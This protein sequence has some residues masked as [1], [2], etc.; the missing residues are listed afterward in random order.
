MAYDIPRCEKQ[1]VLNGQS[2]SSLA[3]DIGRSR[4]LVIN[5]FKGVRVRNNTAKEIIEGMGLTVAKVWIEP[6]RKRA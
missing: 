3:R 6:K 2:K 5:F 4:T 1:L